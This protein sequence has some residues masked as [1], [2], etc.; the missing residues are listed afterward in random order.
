[1]WG[2][3]NVVSHGVGQRGPRSNVQALPQVTYLVWGGLSSS[4][5]HLH[6]PSV[7]W[8]RCPSMERSPFYY[9][10]SY[11][12]AEEHE[13]VTTFFYSEGRDP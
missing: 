4:L 2:G 3:D 12:A 13:T 11:K 9:H 8:V 7:K 10:V 5:L 1:M 6:F